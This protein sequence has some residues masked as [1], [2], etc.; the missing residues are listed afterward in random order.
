VL[1]PGREE[2]I[3]GI[4]V[5]AFRVPHQVRDVSLGLK[6]SH[7]G[8]TLLFSGDSAWTDQFVAHARGA[9]LFLCECCFFERDT[10]NHMN[11]RKL[12]ENLSRLECKNILLTHLGEEML[13]RKEEVR[14]RLAEDG[15]VVEI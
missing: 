11:Y 12:E 1:Q 14:L 7:G 4:G 6:I 9:D 5:L 13:A 3:D 15:M 8:K 2:V 10:P